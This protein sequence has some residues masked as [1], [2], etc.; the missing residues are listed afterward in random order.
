MSP[1]A[2]DRSGFTNPFA[3]TE[4]SS[5]ND[6]VKTQ[7][8]LQVPTGGQPCSEWTVVKSNR[9]K[10]TERKTTNPPGRGYYRGSGRHGWD[11]F[12]RSK[13]DQSGQAKPNDKQKRGN[14]S[15]GDQY[16]GGGRGRGGYRGRGRGGG[17]NSGGGGVSNRGHYRKL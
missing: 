6:T 11:G 9:E 17:G 8:N 16:R 3:D 7:V 12:Y 10:T 5:R 2:T 14:F 13:S 1:L 15:E 4:G